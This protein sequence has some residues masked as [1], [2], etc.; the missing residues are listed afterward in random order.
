MSVRCQAEVGFCCWPCK[1][2][3]SAAPRPARCSWCFG[4]FMH[5]HT[6]VAVQDVGGERAMHK[7]CAEAWRAQHKSVWPARVVRAPRE[8]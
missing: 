2:P 7:A 6:P 8:E 4:K 5:N 3:E 1:C